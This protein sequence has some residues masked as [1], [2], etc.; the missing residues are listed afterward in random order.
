MAIDQTTIVDSIGIDP[1]SGEVLLT[2][3]DHLDWTGEVKEHMFLL[4]EKVNT[5]LRFIESGEV[6]R[7]Y[8]KS[9]GRKFVI[10]IM[11]KFALTDD[12]RSFLDKIEGVLTHAGYKLRFQHLM[13]H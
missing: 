13:S 5:Y 7:K 11:A 1:G 2:I 12:A 4:Q 9:E 6:Y 8:P 3:S 10:N